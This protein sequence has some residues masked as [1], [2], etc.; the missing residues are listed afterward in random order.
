MKSCISLIVVLIV[1][2]SLPA[3]G[4]II[5]VPVDYDSIQTAILFSNNGDTVLVADGI[6]AENINF[7]GK[8]ILLTSQNGPDY[9]TIE[10]QPGVPA[11]T[12]NQ[13]EGRSSI[14]S[15]FTIDGDSSLYGIHIN[16]ASPTI[17]NNI[18]KNHEVG[19]RVDNGGS[20]LIRKNEI[21]LCSHSVYP[22]HN[23]GGI[24]MQGA[25]GALIDSNEIH[26][27]YANVAGGIYLYQCA[28]VTVE[29]NLI[30]S[31]SSVYIG[32]LEISTCDSIRVYNNTLVDNT[33]NDIN[34]GSINCSVSNYVT[35]AGNISAFN[36]EYGICAYQDNPNLVTRY[37]DVYGNNPG[38]YLNWSP[39]TGSISADPLFIDPA[40]D[41][42]NLGGSSPCINAGDPSLP[43]DPDGTIADMGA[44]Y[45]P[46]GP[47]TYG[48]LAGVV[49][50]TFGLPLQNVHVTYNNF[51]YED[52]TD[53]NGQYFIDSMITWTGYDILFSHPD[54]FETIVDN[55]VIVENDTT[56]L[57]VTMTPLPD[58]G[59]ISGIVTDSSMTPIESVY[60][61]ISDLELDTYT[62][63]NGEYIF[64][65]LFPVDYDL[66]FSHPDYIP[67]YFYDVIVL[68]NDTTELNV[69][70]AEYGAIAG[71]VSDSLGSPIENV[72]VTDID[73]GYED[74]T[75]ANGEYSLTSLLPGLHDLSFSHSL[76]GTATIEDVTVNPGQTT[77]LNVTL[78]GLQPCEYAV[79][80]VNFSGAFNVLDPLYGIFYFRGLVTPTPSCECTPG[81]VWYVE[82]D[83]DSSCSYIGLDISYMYN[84]LRHYWSEL[85][86]CPDCPPAGWPSSGSNYEEL[87]AGIDFD[88]SSPVI[89]SGEFRKKKSDNILLTDEGV[90]LWFG[91]LDESPIDVV[92]GA[93]V[94]ID[95]YIQMASDAHVSCFNLPLGA[96]DDYISGF[97]SESLGQTYNMPDWDIDEFVP[98]DSSPPNPA[99][100]SSQSLLAI[101]EFHPP[102]LGDWLHYESPTLIGTFVLQTVNDS[103][104]ANQTVACI[105]PGISSRS[106]AA[107]FG[108]HT[109][110]VEHEVTQHFSPIH[111]LDPN[112]Y[113]GALM[114][115]VTGDS[116][117]PIEGALVTVEGTA[118]LDITDSSG[119]YIIE[120]IIEGIYD[121]GFSH[122]FYHD[123]VL[124]DISIAAN[125]TTTVDV[126]MYEIIYNDIEVWYGTPDGSPIL[127]T[128]GE[129]LNID[130]YVQTGSDIRVEFMAI[131]LGLEDQYFD[132][133]LS[134]DEGQIFDVLLQWDDV[135]FEAPT[136]SPPNPSDWSA[137]T[138]IAFCNLAPPFNNPYFNSTVPTKIASFVVKIPYDTLLVGNT[139][140]CMGPG[141]NQIN[142]STQ[143]GDSLGWLY[144]DFVEHFNPLY[145]VDP[146]SLGG[147]AGTVTDSAQFPIGGVIITVQGTAASDTTDGSGQYS[148]EG[149]IPGT[150]NV[151]FY[152]PDYIPAI[153]ENVE[154]LAGQTTTVDVT[155]FE[156]AGGCVYVVGDV[157]NSGAFNGLDVTYGVSFFKGGPA[158][159][160]S[161]ECTP[162]NIWYVAG[163][164][165][166]S[167]TYNGLDVTYGVGFFKGGPAPVPCSDCPPLGLS[168]IRKSQIGAGK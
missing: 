27:N 148:C 153:E 44:L 125:E 88:Y 135:T 100:W 59:A 81:N 63:I 152:H 65:N 155:L 113:A 69:A 114:G 134:E 4:T 9:T 109:A 106:G 1:L 98:V 104:F 24:R 30:Y 74:T 8:A 130:V 45:Y 157:N 52:W 139:V 2:F 72:I 167:C 67:Q 103:S 162:G 126:V 117:S 105:G 26:H 112:A 5:N 60:V 68:S 108:D 15:G 119:N 159:L 48:A 32:G 143:F 61:V 38:N 142:E 86:P 150:Y 23:G 163:D 110:L 97:L 58:P 138:M 28:N 116:L 160:Y 144:D 115:T 92:P 89:S 31:N 51:G 7:S 127:A 39:G 37:N 131:M 165:N 123:T 66:S 90:E 70:L 79:G 166:N 11:V 136:G 158:P 78:Y 151:S 76:Y 137:E 62:D 19:I 77:I 129:R 17:Y 145:F 25:D 141:L 122:L 87:I 154:V 34:L 146:S 33:S 99:G 107:V 14:L 54:F 95:V 41:N 75:L 156:P 84:Y 46:L 80:D 21:T 111:F 57:N 132:S 53:S 40:N 164:I 140:S 71:T 101:V 147:V 6:Y 20:P 43:L 96:D 83:V 13:G 18:V 82:G 128:I 161:C 3:M 73:A 121:V 168:I 36:N 12:F 56:D 94:E 85:A 49:T 10:M 93:Q 35:V 118:L 47:L 91:N 55:V 124:T 22:P 50:D 29:R 16:N 42:Y 120:N 149:I 64:E 102:Y 133:L